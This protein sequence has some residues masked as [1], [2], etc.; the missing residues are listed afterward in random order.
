MTVQ[1]MA[2]V[3]ARLLALVWLLAVGPADL[4]TT[5]ARFLPRL[6]AESGS[7]LLWVVVARAATTAV[8][9][10]T[11]LGLLR[12][13]PDVWPLAL[14]W[15]VLEAVTMGVVLFTPVVPTNRLPGTAPLI[16]A[17]YGLLIGTVLAAARNQRAGDR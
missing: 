13:L 15:G 17:L 9:V 10:A 5:V 12:R 6:L 2:A 1:A 16:A 7:T 3:V 4:A 14:T 8:G 11:G